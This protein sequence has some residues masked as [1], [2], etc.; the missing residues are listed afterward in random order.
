LTVYIAD[1]ESG[2][3]VFDNILGACNCGGVPQYEVSASA[4]SEK[5]EYQT[6]WQM[7]A[8]HY[9]KQGCYD[10]MA[11]QL[12]ELAPRR[13][14]DIGCGAGQGIR[15]LYRRF[16]CEI[17]ALDEN[18]ECLRKSASGV[19][20]EGM[21]AQLV[22]RFTY[23]ALPGNRHAI[24]VDQTPIS[25][26]RQAVLVQGDPLLDDQLLFSYIRSKAPF[27]ALTIWLCGTFNIRRTCANLDGFDIGGPNEYRLHVQNKTYTLAAELLRSGGVL[28]V[29]DRGEVPATEELRESFLDSHREQASDTDIEVLDINYRLYND[30]ERKGVRMVVTYGS[31]GRVGDMSQLAMLSVRS[32]KP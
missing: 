10:W 25:A 29:V 12:D 14:L 1:R 27:D 30:L 17:L 21:K 32:R 19:R 24:A 8:E 6:H 23:I 28:H 7:N 18:I 20:R 22:E 5:K 4:L 2:A 16:G 3:S 31:S 11:A 13:V 15:A 9:E 26:S